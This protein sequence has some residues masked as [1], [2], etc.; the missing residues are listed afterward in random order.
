MKTNKHYFK[1]L[2]LLLLP[3]SI[4]AQEKVI[5]L[6]SPLPANGTTVYE[7]QQTI[8]LN[9]PFS[10]TASGESTFTGRINESIITPADYI[11]PVAINNRPLNTGLS[12]GTI[13][14]NAGVGQ[15]GAANYQ[16]ELE[17][18][19]G[20]NGVQPTVSLV[21]NSQVGNGI[22]GWGFNISGLSAVNRTLRTIYSDGAAAG[23]L[24]T[25]NAKYAL[26][27]MPLIPVS[28]T[29]GADGVEYRM[30]TENFSRIYS[31]GNYNNTGPDWFE[32]KTKDG[33]ILK[34]G[35]LTGKFKGTSGTSTSYIQAW[36]INRME[37]QDG[38]GVD[39]EYEAAG[40]GLYIKKISYSGNTVE[41]F[42]DSRKDTI[43]V[44]LGSKTGFQDCILRKI[45]VRC[46]G[47]VYRTYDLEYSLDRF[48]RLI[49]VTEGNGTG[50]K[51]NS[52]VFEWGSFPAKTNI[53]VKKAT[54]GTKML[55]M[56]LVL[57]LI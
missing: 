6:T 21:Y 18:P 51:K 1:I 37:N 32:V 50:E 47:D 27:G 56:A 9:P 8:Y 41:F 34:Y 30:E 43:S 31:H 14:G 13:A 38:V 7:A 42:Y 45:I 5:T 46:E 11:A 26:D 3:F 12:V 57:W 48:S 40:M 33:L 20:I 44:Y 55:D 29:N 49:K 16:M 52:T 53:S 54:N 36:Y 10:Y 39:Y 28:G 25:S 19:P 24:T 22:A 4:F 2:L 15:T 23:M 35:N 17:L